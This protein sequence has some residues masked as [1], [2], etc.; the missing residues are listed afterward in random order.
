MQN[1]FLFLREG[2]GEGGGGGGRLFINIIC[3]GRL[4]KKGVYLNGDFI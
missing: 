3:G 1:S 4:I 2:M